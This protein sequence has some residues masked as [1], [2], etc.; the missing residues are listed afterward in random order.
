MLPYAHDLLVQHPVD[1]CH[2]AYGSM[3]QPAIFNSLQHLLENTTAG[4]IGQF[5]HHLLVRNPVVKTAPLRNNFWQSYA[6]FSCMGRF[7]TCDQCSICA[8]FDAFHC[9]VH[10]KK[11][12]SLKYRNGF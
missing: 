8:C 9:H 11:E 6:I 1:S 3:S 2:F 7:F 5:Q 10:R 4:H 12:Q